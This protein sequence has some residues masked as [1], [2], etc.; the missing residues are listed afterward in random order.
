MSESKQTD[1]KIVS[2]RKCMKELC[3][4]RVPLYENGYR[5]RLC[6]ACKNAPKVRKCQSCTTMIPQ[7]GKLKYKCDACKTAPKECTYCHVLKKP[8]EFYRTKGG[9]AHSYCIPCRSLYYKRRNAKTE[10]KSTADD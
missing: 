8:D 7:D 3:F 2:T 9:S 10:I 5:P 6:D 1:F 4:K